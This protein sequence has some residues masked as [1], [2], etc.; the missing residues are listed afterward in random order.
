[1]T[2]LL[3]RWFG[4]KK[5][6]KIRLS[7]L[8]VL[9]YLESHQRHQRVSAP[10]K[11]GREIGIGGYDTITNSYLWLNAHGYLAP[12]PEVHRLAAE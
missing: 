9:L 3:Q 10:D 4:G 6:E 8:K 12:A 11:L 1:M 2:S 5:P 7:P